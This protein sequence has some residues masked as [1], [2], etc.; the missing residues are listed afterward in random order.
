MLQLK[1]SSLCIKHICD[2]GS[3]LQVFLRA[4][5]LEKVMN[6]SCYEVL[7]LRHLSYWL[8]HILP[9]PSSEGS[10][11]NAFTSLSILPRC[12]SYFRVAAVCFLPASALLSAN[13]TVSWI[14]ISTTQRRRA[15][16]VGRIRGRKE[17][18][19]RPDHSA[20]LETALVE[21]ASEGLIVTVCVALPVK[22]AC[23]A[24]AVRSW[25]AS[26]N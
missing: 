15:W 4:D 1:H 26:V 14:S 19:W 18:V 5:K 22:Q 6:G 10:F 12:S 7:I 2:G 17:P 9:L 16:K 21:R 11:P 25:W 20:D 3:Q 23:L 24:P 8:L 13:K